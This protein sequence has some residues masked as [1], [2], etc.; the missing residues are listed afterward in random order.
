MHQAK[1]RSRPQVKIS[2]AI[3]SKTR[4]TDKAKP[5]VIHHGIGRS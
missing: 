1:N 5:Y 3:A 2:D 4:R